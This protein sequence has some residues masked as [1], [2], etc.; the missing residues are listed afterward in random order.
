MGP[1]IGGGDPETLSQ[2]KSLVEKASKAAIPLY[3]HTL[4]LAV[5]NALT[6]Q[7]EEIKGLTEDAFDLVSKAEY[8]DE[9][10]AIDVTSVREDILELLKTE[11]AS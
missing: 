9:P 11:H 7:W 2:L 6:A 1:V 8:D 10:D 4:W 5:T 3:S